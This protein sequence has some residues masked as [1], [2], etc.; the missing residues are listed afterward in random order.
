MIKV[1]KL[2]NKYMQRSLM[3]VCLLCCSVITILATPMLFGSMTAIQGEQGDLIINTNATI[4]KS[5]QSNT[6][7]ED[8]L[9]AE[10]LSVT[11]VEYFI[12]T[13]PGYGKGMKAGVPV[14]EKL[15]FV[16]NLQNFSDGLH[17]LYVR[18]RD[19]RGHWGQTVSHPFIK[20]NKPNLGLEIKLIEYFID[21]DPGYGKGIDAGLPANNN[22]SFTVSSENL[23]D[24]F[25]TICI[26]G[27]DSYGNWSHTVSYPF[28]KKTM[29]EITEVEYF[30]DADPGYGKGIS[31]S[32]SEKGTDTEVSFIADLSGLQPG[33]HTIYV[34]GKNKNGFWGF[35]ESAPFLLEQSD[36]ILVNWLMPLT[37]YP[38][39][40][41]QECFI[42]FE[43]ETNR[44]YQIS[45]FALSGS[46]VIEI[47]ASADKGIIKLEV[48]NLPEGTYLITIYDKE[49]NRKVTKRMIVNHN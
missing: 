9:R 10:N 31:V 25:H 11:E 26:R 49:Q 5:T 44:E 35:L 37:I 46:K 16:A 38:V 43:T 47:S 21:A 40:A 22:L 23:T 20:I 8:T 1:V 34:R 18:V 41:D 15:S 24:G 4:E 39:P 29:S 19:S 45:V 17:T 3:M 36:N 28:V 48:G 27:L 7:Y 6:I 2:I 30:I 13:D 42:C 32:V 33:E 12:D 14:G